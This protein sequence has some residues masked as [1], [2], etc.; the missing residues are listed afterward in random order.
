MAQRIITLKGS[1]VTK[2]MNGLITG[3]SDGL[4]QTK[5]HRVLTENGWGVFSLYLSRSVVGSIFINPLYVN[6]DFTVQIT[7]P[8]NENA[9]RVRTGV[10]NTLAAI[11]NNVSLYVAGDD[12]LQ[13]NTFTPTYNEDNA[14]YDMLPSLKDAANTAISGAGFSTPIVFGIGFLLLI[15]YLKK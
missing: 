2:E 14:S 6:Y 12:M 10:S 15:L 11:F 8:L 1:V 7:A 5:A 9:E 4:E 13:N 3:I